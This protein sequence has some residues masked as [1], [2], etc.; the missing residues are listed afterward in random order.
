M[1]LRPL[2]LGEILDRTFTLYKSNIVLFAAL[3]GIPR[4]PALALG[5][6]QVQGLVEG[7]S[8]FDPMSL[9]L[10]LL[11]YV[12]GIAGYVYSQGSSVITVSELY[13]GRGISINDALRRVS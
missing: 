3:A 1:N 13:L 10:T 2:S 12:V 9:L 4:I 11:T 8:F 7:K 5:L 6:I